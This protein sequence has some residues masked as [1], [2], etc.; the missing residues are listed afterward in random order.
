MTNLLE[1]QKYFHQNLSPQFDKEEIENFIFLSFEHLM[2]FSRV[3]LKLK[4]EQKISEDLAKKFISIVEELQTNKPIQYIL[5][6]TEFY[7]LRF[8]VDENVLIPRQETEEL[9]HWILSK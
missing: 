4:S 6:E 5:G 8:L 7:G 3:D 1:I 2:G 9:V